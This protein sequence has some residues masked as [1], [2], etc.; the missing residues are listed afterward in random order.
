MTTAL[1]ETSAA[2]CRGADPAL[3]FPSAQSGARQDRQVAAAKELCRECPI[4]RPCLTRA[5]EVS[6]GEG[7]WGGFTGPERRRLRVHAARL[8]SL[9]PRL[10]YELRAG[11]PVVL[12]ALDR[13]A[14]AHLLAGLGWSLTRIGEA[15]G[16][17]P[18]AARAAAMTGA[19]AAFY[20]AAEEDRRP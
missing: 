6:E 11:R 7:I 8:R 17:E 16:L 4:R 9:D 13:P 19:N 10:I 2:A 14:V 3:F 1:R 12:P 18:W 20:A 15:L 5:L